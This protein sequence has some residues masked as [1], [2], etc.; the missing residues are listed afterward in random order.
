MNMD[1]TN[2]LLIQENKI[3]DHTNIQTKGKGLFHASN[4][5]YYLFPQLLLQFP[6]MKVHT[7][8][9]M[10]HVKGIN[11]KVTCIVKSTNQSI[12]FGKLQDRSLKDMQHYKP[13]LLLMV[14]GSYQTSNGDDNSG[15]MKTNGRH[16]LRALGGAIQESFLGTHL[17]THGILL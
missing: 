1:S 15:E 2:Q 11:H 7:I 12:S 6:C 14:L 16:Q 17:V 3:N 8:G 4:K 10:S 13:Q 5:Y 9:S